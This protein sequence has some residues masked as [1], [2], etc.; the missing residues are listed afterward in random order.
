MYV[1]L[2]VKKDYSDPKY[3]VIISP[4][5]FGFCC[6]PCVF[7]NYVYLYKYLRSS[8]ERRR[9]PLGGQYFTGEIKIAPDRSLKPSD[10]KLQTC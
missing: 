10:G 2:C 7:M 4:H 6:P 3:G 9:L 1:I 8:I 5:R